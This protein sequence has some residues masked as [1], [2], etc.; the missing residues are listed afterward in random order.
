L[1]N[2]VAV[3]D[4]GAEQKPAVSAA[5]QYHVW[6]YEQELWRK[7]T[8][9]G[10]PCVKSVSD[11][12]NYQEILNDLGPSLIIEF[13]THA[14]GSAL[15]FAEI[16]RL[17]SGTGRVLSVDIDH[18][19]VLDAVRNND[20]IELLESD[21]KAA[22][23]VERI[24]QLRAEWPGKAFFILD[25]DHSK[26]HVLAELLQLRAVTRPDD[27]VIVEDGNIGH[28]VLPGWGEGPFE[29]VQDYMARH[30]DDYRLDAERERKFGFTFAQG[31][32]LVRR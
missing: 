22:I 10:V 5:E 29:A 31:G 6:Y 19:K 16:L 12:W 17:I 27:Y 20:R 18:S 2:V 8:F 11:M 14:G 23:V 7:T 26:E 25:S 21:S 30:P 9:L 32:F 1:A 13:G 3:T 24:R 4:H 15:F 28:S